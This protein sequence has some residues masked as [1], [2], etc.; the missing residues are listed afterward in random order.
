MD[1]DTKIISMYENIGY[2]GMY[3]TDVCITIL[4]FI[5]TLGIVSFASYKSIINELKHNWNTNKCNPIVIPF[6]G[7]IM[8]VP[9][10]TT[11]ETTFENFNYCI[12]QD[13]TAIF[14]II[15]MPFEFVL[16]LTISFLDTV[17]ML[18]MELIEFLAWLKS[19]L[20]GLFGEFYNKILN[21]VI[22][23]IEMTVH[24]RDML[25]KINGIITAS[26]FMIMNIYNL[27][28]SGVINILTILVN[29]LL[30]LIASL[31]VM[32]AA[33]ALFFTNPF[34]II[35]G[36]IL[37]VII[38]ACL[39]GVV[40]PAITITAIMHSTV[41]DLFHESSPNA[42]DPPHNKSKKKKK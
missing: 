41:E 15:M 32:M 10:Q 12:Q 8:P 27:T 19:I 37:E 22:P 20:S 26:L 6:A 17:L 2:L 18:I 13:M 25:G 28:V 16:Y 29:L 31:V 14:S 40:L 21:F 11:I 23:I 30:V 7:L 24:I 39:V 38:V 1:V 3:G 4:L 42:P 9:G 34:T 33:A 36:I 35:P 5:I